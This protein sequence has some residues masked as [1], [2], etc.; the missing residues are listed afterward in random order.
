LDVTTVEAISAHGPSLQTTGD[1]HTDSTQ[2]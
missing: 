1:I 2:R